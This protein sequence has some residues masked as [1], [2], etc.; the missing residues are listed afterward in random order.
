MGG[1]PIV[2]I[3]GFCSGRRREHANLNGTALPRGSNRSF[4]DTL[5]GVACKTPVSLGETGGMNTWALQQLANRSKRRCLKTETGE[6]NAWGVR[7]P[8]QT[9]PTPHPRRAHPA[10]QPRQTTPARARPRTSRTLAACP[11]LARSPA[12]KSSRCRNTGSFIQ[13][14]A[15]PP[16]LQSHGTLAKRSLYASAESAIPQPSETLQGRHRTARKRFRTAP[17]PPPEPP[18]SARPPRPRAAP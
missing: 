11:S 6:M 15:R 7:R 5:F 8:R 18:V 2:R 14:C 10:P 4:R 9:A 16:S 12:Q 17:E 13:T 1:L 3:A